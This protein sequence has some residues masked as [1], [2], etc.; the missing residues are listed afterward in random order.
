MSKNLESL[1]SYETHFKNCSYYFDN[2]KSHQHIIYV[3]DF[4]LGNILWNPDVGTIP[5]ISNSHYESLL[6]DF[7]SIYNLKQINN[8]W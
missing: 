1:E 2:L 8:M 5:F 3:G 6:L 4:N 7:L